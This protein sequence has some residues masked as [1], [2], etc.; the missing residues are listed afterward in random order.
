MLEQTAAR[1]AAA[2]AELREVDLP[3]PFG[4]VEALQRILMAVDAA[5]AFQDEWENHQDALSK[6]FRALVERG[7]E[8]SV[9]ER[10]EAEAT[11]AQCRVRLPHLFDEGEIILTPSA[12]GRR[13]SDWG[14]R[15]TPCSTG[16][17]RRCARRV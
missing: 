14:R 4:R 5:Q 1:L 10:A 13:R 11:V 7:L 17:G 8:T 16:L 9:A 6:R 3:E 2:G 12:P 15:E